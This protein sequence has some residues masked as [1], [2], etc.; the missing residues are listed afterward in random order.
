MRVWQDPESSEEAHWRCASFPSSWQEEGG[1]W[2]RPTGESAYAVIVVAPLPEKTRERIGHTFYSCLRRYDLAK[3]TLPEARD[4]TGESSPFPD[5][6]SVLEWLQEIPDWEASVVRGSVEKGYGVVVRAATGKSAKHTRSLAKKVYEA[7]DTPWSAPRVPDRLNVH[8]RTWD[9]IR[10]QH[11]IDYTEGFLSGMQKRDQGEEQNQ[12]YLAGWR[13][14][15]EYAV[16]RARLPGWFI[17]GAEKES[18]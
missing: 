5:G 6:Y 10:V 12:A 11:P 2:Y 8:H 7:G 17:K 16:G 15:W 9:K 3:L 4:L 13:H 14:G 18:V 1:I